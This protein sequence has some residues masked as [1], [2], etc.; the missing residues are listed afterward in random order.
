MIKDRSSVYAWMT[1]F[2]CIRLSG[3]WKTHKI[4]HIIR[5]DSMKFI[6][7][8]FHNE[9][10]AYSLIQATII[11]PVVFLLIF[12]VI[13]IGLYILHMITLASY[14]QKIAVL[15]AREVS[16]PGYST[17]L[18]ADKYSSSAVEADLGKTEEGKSPFDGKVNI[19]NKVENIKTRAYRY[20]YSPLD[21]K[22]KKYYEGVLTTL[23]K[24]NSILN[25]DALNNVKVEIDCDN[26]FITQ[27]IN[28]S[29]EQKLMEFGVLTFFGIESPSVKVSATTPVSDTDEIVRNTDFAVDAVEVLADKLGIDT[30]KMKE[31]VNKGISIIGLNEK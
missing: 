23:V 15:T 27:F 6:K 24:N 8:L 16:S 25:G 17:I 12:F 4:K 5:G 3:V 31:A 11:Y 21:D 29:I 30:S 18:S 9:D 28:V 22:S 14:A 13:Y 20:W 7:K 10:G 2:P 19:D 1:R 26:Y